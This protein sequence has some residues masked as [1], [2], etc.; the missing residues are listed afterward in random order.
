MSY[1]PAYASPGIKEQDLAADLAELA[2]DPLEYVNY[3]YRWGE[4]E[5][6]AFDG[7][8]D[9]Q[10]GFLRELGEEI[11]SRDFDG[12]NAVMP[13]L[14]STVSGHGVGKTALVGMVSDFIRSTRPNSKGRVTANTGRQLSTVT[15][16]EILKW[17]KRSVTAHWWRFL[18]NAIVH[19]ASEEWRLDALVWDEKAPEAFAGLHAATS[20]PYLIIDEAS[21]V[22]RIICETGQGG[23]TDG[24]PFMFLFG[25]GTRTSG[26]FYETHHKNRDRWLR[27]KVDSRKARVSNK[28]LLQ[29]WIEDNGIDSDFCKIRVLGEFPKQSSAQ[30]IAS[31][32]VRAARVREVQA[33]LTDPVIMAVDV[34]RFGDDRT[35]IR[36]RKGRDARSFKKVVL[37]GADTMQT[38]GRVAELARELLPDAIFIDGGGVGGGVVDRCRQ[39]N[40]PNIHEINF[41]GKSPDRDYADMAA[42]MWAK[43]RDALKDGLAI[44]DDDDLETELTVREYFFDR[45]NAI[46]LEAKDDLKARGEVSPDDADSI[47]LTYA[48]PVGPRDPRRTEAAIAG[49]GSFDGVQGADYDPLAR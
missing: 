45:N 13:V 27:F 23:L 20:S 22:P 17:G 47:A 30:F 44:E 4:G 35:I 15:W 2:L 18:S 5:L 49:T 11:R 43:M 42:Y 38:A 12:A 1:A 37:R 40:V 3:A 41:G 26:F 10:K 6:A 14:A 48:Y 7:P 28:K 9:W 32:I 34:A 24:E 21:R 16:A 39:L 19:K 29:Q 25:N 33:L 36:V 31:D 8:D 46:R